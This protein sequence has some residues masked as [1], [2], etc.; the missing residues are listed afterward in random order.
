LL[1]LREVAAPK[2]GEKIHS[3]PATLY[4]PDPGTDFAAG[5]WM[6]G[7]CSSGLARVA[8]RE[9]NNNKKDFDG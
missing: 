5:A 9:F 3:R 4:K 7:S 8:L 2:R 6:R 1:H